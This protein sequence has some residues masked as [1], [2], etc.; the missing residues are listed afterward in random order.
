[1]DY[2]I[3]GY[4]IAK[5]YHLDIE[6]KC[7][8]RLSTNSSEKN[9]LF[10]ALFLN[11]TMLNVF[12]Y[13]LQNGRDRSI[14][15]QELFSKVWEENDLS[16]STQRLWQVLNGLNKKLSLLGMHDGMVHYFRGEGYRLTENDIIT[17]YRKDCH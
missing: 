14:T 1:M 2:Q 4:L 15:K 16:P 17:L 10:G 11:Q 3:H 13:L 9:I 5:E 7:L 8:F 6:N 12:L